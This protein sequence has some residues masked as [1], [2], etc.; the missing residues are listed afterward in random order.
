[1]VGA[2][3]AREERW[4]GFKPRRRQ[5]AIRGCLTYRFANKF[6]PTVLTIPVFTGKSRF[7]HAQPSPDYPAR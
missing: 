6:A 4:H 7:C 1:M 2:E 5:V 3:L